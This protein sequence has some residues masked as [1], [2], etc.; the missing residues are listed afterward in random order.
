MSEAKESG[1]LSSLLPHRFNSSKEDK[2]PIQSG[3]VVKLFQLKFK[4]LREFRLY[5]EFGSTS[6]SLFLKFNLS[7]D[8]SKP[9]D[10]GIFDISLSYRSSSLSLVYEPIHSGRLD[11]L[12]PPSPNFSKDKRGLMPFGTDLK[13]FQPNSNSFIELLKSTDTELNYCRVNLEFLVMK[14]N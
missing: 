10:F 4:T 5:N 11:N 1:N 7:R 12:F 14:E 8:L 3:R 6:N 9:S 13:L 2:D